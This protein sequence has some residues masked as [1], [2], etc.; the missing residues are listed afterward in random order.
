MESDQLTIDHVLLSQMSSTERATSL[1]VAETL[2]VVYAAIDALSID[3]W[4]EWDQGFNQ[5]VDA[6][7]RAVTKVFNQTFPKP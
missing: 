4:D 5:G 2:N 7:L 3:P 6:A 1:L